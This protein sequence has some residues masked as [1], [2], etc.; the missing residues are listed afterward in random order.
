MALETT[1]KDGN[2]QPQGV[3]LAKRKRKK[4]MPIWVVGVVAALAGILVGY[5]LR[6]ASARAHSAA[7]EALATEREKRAGELTGEIDALRASVAAKADDAS[8][9]AATV[10]GLTAKLENEQKNM[11]EKVALLETAKKA[12]SDQFQTLA[13]EILDQKSKS[14]SEGSQKEIGNLLGPLKTQIEDFRKKVEEAQTDS[15][16]GVARL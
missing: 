6:N 7:F 5:W 16:T 14:F 9:S 1:P 12:L 4:T 8:R 10:A 13:G 2:A 11:A 15:K 3:Y